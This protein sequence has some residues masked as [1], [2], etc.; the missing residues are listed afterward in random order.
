MWGCRN[1]L[2]KYTFS[3][4]H[5]ICINFF[6]QFTKDLNATVDKGM[7]KYDE[8]FIEIV[9]KI[10]IIYTLKHFKQN[11]SIFICNNSL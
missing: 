5:T 8:L 9:E 7:L 3:V 1:S 10:N 11:N 6:F 4:K 2:V